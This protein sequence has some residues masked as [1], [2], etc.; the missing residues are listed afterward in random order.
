MK[1]LSTGLL[2]LFCHLPALANQQSEE[3]L[4]TQTVEKYLISQHKVQEQLMDEALH[5]KLAKRTYWRSRTG[6]E[7]IMETSRN[8]MLRVAKSYNKSGSKFP[9]P[10][11]IDIEIFDIDQRAASV[12]LTADDWIDYMHLVKTESGNWK[13]L[14][15]LW[16]YHDTNKHISE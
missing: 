1:Y 10:P 3:V 6:D 16:Q 15:V 12:K 2:L 14:N 8:T 4:I 5:E 9:N 13:I 7:F 11:R